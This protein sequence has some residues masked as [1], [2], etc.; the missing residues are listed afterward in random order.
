M[1]AQ[2]GD[3]GGDGNEIWWFEGK[4]RLIGSDFIQDEIRWDFGYIINVTLRRTS[5][6]RGR[7]KKFFDWNKAEQRIRVY[8]SDTRCHTQYGL[9]IHM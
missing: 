4:M 8:G 7:Q 9:I 2:V 1:A 3:V 5:S 6:K